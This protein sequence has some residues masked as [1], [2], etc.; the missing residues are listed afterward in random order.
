MCRARALVKKTES[1]EM[2]RYRN[3]Q[4]QLRAQVD[5]L[6]DEIATL[7]D[8]YIVARKEREL[9]RLMGNLE[10]EEGEIHSVESLIQNAKDR[11]R[12][13]MQER[14]IARRTGNEISRWH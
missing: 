11:R 14:T 9:S 4:K 1:P 12:R 8:S 5:N 2:E 6:C 3:Y 10:Y 7:D 13:T